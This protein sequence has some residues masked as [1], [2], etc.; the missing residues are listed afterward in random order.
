M[1]VAGGYND[2][3]AYLASAELYD[4]ST[5]TWTATGN[6][7]IARF[8]HTATLLAN[9][10]VLV[11]GGYDSRYLTSAELY[12][13]ATGT[14]TLTGRLNTARLAHTAALLPGG[15]VLVAGG[16][17]GSGILASAELYDPATGNWTLTGSLND[18][19]GQHT[20]TLLPDD[21]V[22][23]TG[24]YRQNG[25]DLASA[26]LYDP[27]TGTWTLTGSL[28]T[29]RDAHTAT[30]LP[31]GEVLVAGG[32]GNN[33]ILASAELYDPGITAAT[34]VDGSG[35]I[36]NNQGREVTF[37]FSAQAGDSSRLGQFT[38]CDTAAGKCTAKARVQSLSIT[39]NTAGFS[40][41]ARLDGGTRVTFTVNVTDNGEP[42]TLDTI[43]ISLSNGYSVSGNLTTGDIRI[44]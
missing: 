44:Q 37:R 10:E 30:L 8:G 3:S 26:E 15:E 16:G 40:G 27:A 41:Q 20:A 38:F 4:P 5:G 35:S 9:G 11:A 19:R 36:E 18:A 25:N 24:G 33:T 34:H 21:R 17:D 31:N 22:L 39:G 6:L 29:A 7:N 32:S 28:N 43:S 23:V 12:D 2:N 13:P 42:G 14:W 1:L